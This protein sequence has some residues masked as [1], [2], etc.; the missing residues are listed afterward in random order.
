MSLRDD[1]GKGIL[2]VK[3]RQSD[4]RCHLNQYALGLIGICIFCDPHL[5]AAVRQR[6]AA[7]SGFGRADAANG[8]PLA[9]PLQIDVGTATGSASRPILIAP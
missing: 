2:S 9:L 4:P 5:T 7:L 8:N 6:F 1:P 3:L